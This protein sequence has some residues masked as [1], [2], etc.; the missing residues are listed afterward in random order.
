MKRKSMG[1]LI[2]L[3]L[4][5]FSSNAIDATERMNDIQQFGK[6]YYAEFAMP[7]TIAYRIGVES[8]LPQ[9][10]ST[11]YIDISPLTQCKPSS[12]TINHF[13]GYKQMDL[14]PFLPVSYKISGQ[15][16]QDT[17]TKPSIDEGY[18]FNPIESLTANDLLK[19]KGKGSLSF[20]YT[21]PAESKDPIQKIYF[22]LNGFPDAYSRAINSCK[23]NM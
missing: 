14:P 10:K 6:W 5:S 7:D 13:I 17:F 1:M 22:P 8:K 18:L 19:T 15:E 9:E 23:E 12:V 16:K 11:L 2:S 3:L 20:W 4:V 21:P